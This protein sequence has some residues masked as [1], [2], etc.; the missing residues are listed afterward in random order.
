MARH[1]SSEILIDRPP[2]VVWKIL[3]DLDG[4]QDWNPFMIK[5]HG[6]VTQGSHLSI[7]AKA[8]GKIFTLKP[9][10]TECE[11]TKGFSWVGRLGGVPG[12]FTGRHHHELQATPEGTRYIQSEDFTGVMVPFVGK[13]LMD[14]EA[15]FGLMNEALKSRAEQSRR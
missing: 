8:D 14:T 2:D 11:E 10:V 12:I 13:M 5:A 9:T 7:T 1:I 4:F 15:A 3:S 6:K